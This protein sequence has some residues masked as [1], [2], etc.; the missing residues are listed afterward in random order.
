M[1]AELDGRVCGI[2]DCCCVA[3]PYNQIAIR[4]QM[5]IKYGLELDIAEDAGGCLMNPLKQGCTGTYAEDFW[6][7]TPNFVC[8]AP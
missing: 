7:V 5:R 4:R 3:F 1:K 2:C 8:V 6:Y